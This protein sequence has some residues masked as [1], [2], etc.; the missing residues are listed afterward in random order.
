MIFR[1][2]S[3]VKEYRDDKLWPD[4]RIAPE[5]II[6]FAADSRVRMIRRK[7]IASNF[8]A[9]LPTMSPSG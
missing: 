3:R 6:D 7:R 1:D 5:E 9:Q 8:V 4:E 2:A